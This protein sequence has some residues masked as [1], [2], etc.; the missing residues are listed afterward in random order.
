[1]DRSVHQAR[2]ILAPIFGLGV[3][4]FIAGIYLT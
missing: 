1:M 3:G 4:L 2:W